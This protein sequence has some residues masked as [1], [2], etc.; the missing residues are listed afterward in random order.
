MKKQITYKKLIEFCQQAEPFIEKNKDA[1]IKIYGAINSVLK[2]VRKYELIDEYNEKVLSNQLS[3]CSVDPKTNII[4]KEDGQFAYT[5]EGRK[6]LLAMGKALLK[7]TVEIN[8]RI[9]PGNELIEL[10]EIQREAFSG[11]VIPEIDEENE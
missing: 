9:F 4:I 2:Q 3:C 5:V 11:I 8:I 10:N 1:D 7:E 6:K